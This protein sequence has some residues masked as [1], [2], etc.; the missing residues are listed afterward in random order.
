MKTLTAYTD[1]SVKPKN[2]GYGG[3]AFLILH[4]NKTYESSGSVDFATSNG[5]ELL[6]LLEVLRFIEK[7]NLMEGYEELVIRSDSAY[8]CKGANLWLPTWEKNGFR[9]AYSP[10]IAVK[11][12]EDW[13]SVAVLKRKLPFRMEWVRGHNLDTHNERCDVLAKKAVDSYM[14]RNR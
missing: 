11:N 8:V 2:P 14:L 3:W 10:Q 6:G 13:S 1:G 4:E 12:G 5:A 7:H 9:Q